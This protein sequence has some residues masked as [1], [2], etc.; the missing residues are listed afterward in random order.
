MPAKKPRATAGFLLAAAVILTIGAWLRLDRIDQLP[1]FVDEGGHVLAGLEP[2]VRELIDPIG[3]GKPGMLWIFAPARAWSSDPLAGART[4]SALAGVITAAAIGTTLF[5]FSGAPAALLGLG[6]WA[7]F[8]YAVFHERLALLDP[9]VACFAACALAAATFASRPGPNAKRLRFSAFA[10]ALLGAACAVKISAVFALVWLALGYT[11]L[12]RRLGQP[13]VDRRCLA[14]GGGFLVALLPF[15]GSLP[16]LGARLA[17]RGLLPAANAHGVPN[18]D[19]TAASAIA[20]HFSSYLRWTFGY[21]GWPLGLLVAAAVAAALL[22]GKRR[23]LGFAVAWLTALALGSAV[24]HQPYARYALADQVPLVVFL[25]AA[26]ALPFSTTGSRFRTSYAA[27]LAITAF[28]WFQVDGRIA[29]S[30]QLA[31]LPAGEIAQYLTGPWSGAGTGDAVQLL[32]QRAERD[33]APIIVF[34][35][36]FAKPGAYALMLAARRTD[37]GFTVVPATFDSPLAVGA[38]KAAVAKARTLLGPRLKVFVL[39][40]GPFLD[41]TVTLQ[42]AGVR[43]TTV[44]NRLQPDGLSGFALLECD[45]ITL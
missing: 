45:P 26:L 7:L 11:L 1:P 23:A 8:P 5:I 36:R 14:F 13:L 9:F 39:A 17:Q 29:R 32:T 37:A 2:A 10:G 21:G 41:E 16:H 35:Q 4:M 42:H 12:Q 20:G 43:T 33:R 40:E 22:P 19:V 24:Y 44:L 15:A 31:P 18:S 25:G 27:A 30:P 38:M 3:E 34:T 6:L 28:V